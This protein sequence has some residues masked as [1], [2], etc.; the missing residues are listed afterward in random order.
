MRRL[1]DLYHAAARFCSRE[2]IQAVVDRE[3]LSTVPPEP[4]SLSQIATAR[5]PQLGAA[6]SLARSKALLD[7][8]NGT[9]AGGRAGLGVVRDRQRALHESEALHNELY[10]SAPGAS[11]AAGGFADR[12]VQ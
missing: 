1:I 2:S 9:A 7:A 4:R 5:R 11:R 12:I 10:Q 6:A 8:L 3:L